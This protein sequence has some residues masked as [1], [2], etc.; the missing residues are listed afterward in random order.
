MGNFQWYH[1][2]WALGALILVFP[3]FRWALRDQRWPLYVTVWLAIILGAALLYL[4]L[5]G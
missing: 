2:L 4:L 3:A 1:I 5:Y